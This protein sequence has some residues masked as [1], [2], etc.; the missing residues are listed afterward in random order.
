MRKRGRETFRFGKHHMETWRINKEAWKSLGTVWR[1][2]LSVT[3]W[4]A[5]PRHLNFIPKSM[6]EPLKATELQYVWHCI[7]YWRLP[8]KG[9]RGRFK[10]QGLCGELKR[11]WIKTET[12]GWNKGQIYKILRCTYCICVG[13][14]KR[15]CA[16]V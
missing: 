4:W 6:W 16:G 15:K 14:G 8:I 2:V 5:P 3:E 9:R 12:K 11:V 7:L 10:G 1:R 13:S